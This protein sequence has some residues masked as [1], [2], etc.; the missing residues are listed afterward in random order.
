[1]YVYILDQH[2]YGYAVYLNVSQWFVNAKSLTKA[3]DPCNILV[4]LGVSVIVA[5][6]SQHYRVSPNVIALVL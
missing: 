6:V 5:Q 2:G 4:T 3:C 1:M